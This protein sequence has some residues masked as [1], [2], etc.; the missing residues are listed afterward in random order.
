M[1]LFF[2][3]KHSYKL[4]WLFGIFFEGFKSLPDFLKLFF[5]Y[6]SF[7]IIDQPSSSDFIL[8]RS[9]GET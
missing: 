2:K 5:D 7:W 4:L 8:T 9:A 6:L 1:K 3:F